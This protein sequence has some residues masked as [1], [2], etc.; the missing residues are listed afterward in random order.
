MGLFWHIA[1]HFRPRGA[2]GF[3]ES[4]RVPTGSCCQDG[5][6]RAFQVADCID[7]QKD[8]AAFLSHVPGGNYSLPY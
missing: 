6:C 8:F 4:Y 7:A 1:A 5:F 2:P 3:L